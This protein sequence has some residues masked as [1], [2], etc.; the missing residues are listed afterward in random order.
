[1]RELG[2]LRGSCIGVDE[3][4]SAAENY[5][6]QIFFRFKFGSKIFGVPKELY[7]GEPEVL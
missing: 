1:M 3:T 7:K 2:R 6:D 4:P 5:Q